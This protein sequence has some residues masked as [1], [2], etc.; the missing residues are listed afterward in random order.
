MG[1]IDRIEERKTREGKSYTLTVIEG[2]RYSIWKS[3]LVEGLAQGDWIEYEWKVNNNY[4]NITAVKK[5]EPPPE[6]K[7]ITKYAVPNEEQIVRMGRM[8]ALKSASAIVA[9]GF[10]GTPE[11]KRDLAVSI[12]KEFERY[13]FGRPVGGELENKNELTKAEKRVQ[14]AQKKRTPFE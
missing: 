4:K 13:I 6:Y 11:E 2:E 7:A 1:R 10:E 9:R 12:A 14:T 5:V 8:S 3:S